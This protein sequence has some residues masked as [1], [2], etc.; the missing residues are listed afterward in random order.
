M[1]G[2][3]VALVLGCGGQDASYLCEILLRE[4]WEVH[5][6]YRHSS[7]YP[8][9]LWRISHLLNKITL[10]VGDIL[11]QASLLD[12]IGQVKPSVVYN[13]ADQ[14]N[15]D[16]SFS[17]PHYNQLVT[18]GGCLNV[19]ECVRRVDRTIRVFQ[20]VSATMFGIGG[21]TNQ[22]EYTTFNPLSPY[23]ICKACAFHWCY[24]YRMVH[25]MFVSTAIFYNHDSVRRRGDYLL[26]KICEKAVLL[27][28]GF[29]KEPLELG[30]LDM[31]VDIGCVGEYMEAAY[32]IMGLISPCDF[33]I[34]TGRPREIKAL[35]EKAFE[36]CEL[37]YGPQTIRV[38]PGNMRP[39]PVPRLVA[40]I[41][42]ASDVFGFNPRMDA[43]DM[44]KVILEHYKEGARE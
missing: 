29:S 37:P 28:H 39:G 22:D 20:P 31:V 40:D 17:V 30:C 6:L 7:S 32:K 35:V 3:R 18:A 26:H 12:I 38:N 8:N 42:R 41:T 44:L 9:N 5:G 27:K 25:G 11:D 4:G 10:H 15:V 19:L 36:E 1:S 33:V 23:A 21:D 16:V 34:G 14:D 2:R 13:E 43:M 24:Y